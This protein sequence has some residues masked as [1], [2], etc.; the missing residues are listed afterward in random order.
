MCEKK[1]LGIILKQGEKLLHFYKNTRSHNFANPS[2]NIKII[3]A[4]PSG[5]FI[6]LDGYPILYNMQPA[7]YTLEH[8]VMS[9][10]GAALGIM[11]IKGS[12]DFIHFPLFF[13]LL[14]CKMLI[15]TQIT[16]FLTWK[17]DPTITHHITKSQS[18]LP[19]HIE[20]KKYYTIAL[21]DYSN[22]EYRLN[23]H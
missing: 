16:F 3:K 19:C 21:N 10:I 9:N 22:H 15:S 12:V 17:S 6:S 18:G 5:N 14:R 11:K 8:F 2:I 4:E 13:N 20:G 7:R 23:G 1:T